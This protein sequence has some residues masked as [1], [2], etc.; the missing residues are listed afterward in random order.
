MPD[1]WAFTMTADKL[2][3]ILLSQCDI[4]IAGTT[5]GEFHEFKAIWDTGATN[6]AITQDVVDQCGLK[7]IGKARVMHAGIGDDPDETDLYIVDLKLP[8]RVLV[9]N[10]A[11]SR[12]GFTGGN[13]LIGIDIINRGDFESLMRMA[14]LSSRFSFRRRPTATLSKRNRYQR[15]GT[16]KKDAPKNTSRISAH[17]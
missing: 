2:V 13:V 12:G 1:N 16:G 11:V 8:N 9:R 3:N 4:R 15:H 10:V 17:V 5:P 7:P 14:E 6:S